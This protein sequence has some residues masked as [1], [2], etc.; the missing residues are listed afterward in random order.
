MSTVSGGDVLAPSVTVSGGDAGG[1]WGFDYDALYD[2]VY[3]ASLDAMAAYSQTV[4]DGQT[5]NGTALSYFE[6]ILSNQVIPVDYVVYVGESYRYNK[7]TYYEYCMAYGDLDLSGTHFTGDGTIVTM[8]VNG[9]RGVTYDYNQSIDLY[10]PLYYSRS[11]LGDYSGIIDYDWSGFL[12]L[13]FLVVG[14]LVWFVR[15]LT[16]LVY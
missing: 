14:G 3:D 2:A 11:N 7:I 9:N 6:G 8:R 13:L 16:R 15:K 5:V 10:A 4:T 12:M 1:V